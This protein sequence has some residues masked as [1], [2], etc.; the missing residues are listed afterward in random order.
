MRYT[1]ASE[2][3]VEGALVAWISTLT[4]L[5]GTLYPRV[6]RGICHLT[7]LS[8]KVVGPKERQVNADRR[9]GLAGLSGGDRSI[10][11]ADLGGGGFDG[12]IA[13]QARGAQIGAQCFQSLV[14]C[15]RGSCREGV[16]LGHML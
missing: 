3:I 4:H 10:P 5:R 15:E 13:S 11:H 1:K 9:S 2:V 16:S 14:D 6:A 7:N 8:Q 12:E